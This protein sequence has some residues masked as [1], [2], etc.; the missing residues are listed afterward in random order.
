M[1]KKQALHQ[2]IKLG[3]AFI[4]LYSA[5]NEEEWMSAA[6]DVVSRSRD[7]TASDVRWAMQLTCKWIARHGQYE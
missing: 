7:L 3:T 5:A 4:R 2:V 6:E 1:E